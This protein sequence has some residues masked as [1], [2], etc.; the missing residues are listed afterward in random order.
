MPITKNILQNSIDYPALDFSSRSPFAEG[1][2]LLARSMINSCITR[3]KLMVAGLSAAALTCYRFGNPFDSATSSS[4]WVPFL[5]G[6]STADTSAKP[7]L[8]IQDLKL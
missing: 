5:S 7:L 4:N 3:R 8:S 6:R 1:E 2:R